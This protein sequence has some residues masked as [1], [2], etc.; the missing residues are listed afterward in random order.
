MRVQELV[1]EV[2]RRQ[3]GLLRPSDA[4]DA[5][6]PP[7]ER[8]KRLRAARTVLSARMQQ[9]RQ[10]AAAAAAWQPGGDGSSG[11]FVPQQPVGNAADADDG[12]WGDWK[13]QR[14]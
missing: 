9:Q 5:A 7:A 6:R 2:E 1:A 3:A 12:P 11:G 10:Q 14:L 8:Q 13:R 4:T